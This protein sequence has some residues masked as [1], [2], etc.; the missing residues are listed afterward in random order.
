MRYT[1]KLE[2]LID[3]LSELSSAAIALLNRDLKF[4]GVNQKL[5]TL[6]N[7][8]KED[9][10]DRSLFDLF[11]ELRRALSRKMTLSM[12]T[13]ATRITVTIYRA[14]TWI[15]DIYPA[16]Q[17]LKTT[18]AI[19]VVIRERQQVPSCP[20]CQVSCRANGDSLT[21]RELQVL[22]LIG[23]GQTTKEI[24][25]ALQIAEGTV[26]DHRKKICRKLGLH[27]TC[28][29]AAC[30]AAHIA[31]SC[32]FASG[33]PA[34]VIVPQQDES[35]AKAAELRHV[36]SSGPRRLS[37]PRGGGAARRTSGNWF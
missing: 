31:G 23:R 4:V 34:G 17:A 27:S 2:E 28:E 37:L 25:T 20:M 16:P 9:H 14:A 1:P 22:H 3:T 7:T 35:T 18:A 36:E 26:S 10:R 11:P 33:P 21:L 13:Q 6:D 15:A 30:A 24:A 5:A 32:R 12:L 19:L 8:R 29:L